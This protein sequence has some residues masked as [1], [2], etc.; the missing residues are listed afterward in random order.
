[1]SY[2]G[3]IRCPC[4]PQ[5]PF[6]VGRTRWFDSNARARARGFLQVERHL[7]PTPFATERT[8]TGPPATEGW[9]PPENNPPRG[10]KLV[11]KGPSKSP[12]VIDGWLRKVL[13]PTP[14]CRGPRARL[15]GRGTH[16]HRRQP[17]PLCETWPAQAALG[18]IVAG[19]IVAHT[20]DRVFYNLV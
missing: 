15:P 5:V 1:M 4:F 11:R 20:A 6:C 19:G 8:P 18:G 2:G 10:G 3:G 14:R 7:D 17:V 12:H 13:S 9:T 16:R